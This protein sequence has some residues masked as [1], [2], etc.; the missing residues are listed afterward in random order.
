MAAVTGEGS[1]QAPQARSQPLLPTDCW[2]GTVV[3]SAKGS[4]PCEPLCKLILG[5]EMAKGA[6]RDPE[7]R[8][9][10]SLAY[11]ATVSR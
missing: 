10:Q 5:G 4:A 7:A 3:S 2:T 1:R 9:S 8:P 6:Q 11:F